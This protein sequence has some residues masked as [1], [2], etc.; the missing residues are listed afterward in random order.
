[1]AESVESE[2][3]GN[4]GR[5]FIRKWLRPDPRYI[6]LIAHGYGEHSGRYEHVAEALVAEGAVVYAPD[7]LGHGR[8]DGPQA[9]IEQGEDLSADLHGVAELARDEHP[10]LPMILIGHSMGGLVAARF[11][12]RHGDELT[13]LVLSGPAIGANPAMEALAELDPIPDMP[14]DPDVL[15]RDPRVGEAYASDPLV[16]HG[17]FQLPTLLELFAGVAAVHEGPGLGEL[18]TLWIHGEDDMLIPLEHTRAAIEVIRGPATEE[19]IYPGARHEVFNETNSDEVIADTIAFL[20][21][22]LG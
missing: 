20:N 11:A 21:R 4:K 14:I 9:L 15:S 3:E 7:H 19:K 16:Y 6:A 1:M 22:V 10:D 18:P 12:Q 2:I 5:I 17:P 13:A 8:S